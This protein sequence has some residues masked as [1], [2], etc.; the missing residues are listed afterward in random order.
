MVQGWDGYS[1]KV[2]PVLKNLKDL[3]GKKRRPS[4][5]SEGHS[6]IHKKRGAVHSPL[7]GAFSLDSR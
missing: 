2:Q 3:F 7:R 6:S 5:T 4:W 1:T